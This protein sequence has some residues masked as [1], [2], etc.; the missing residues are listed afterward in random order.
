MSRSGESWR[1]SSCSHV[2]SPGGVKR[3]EQPGGFDEQY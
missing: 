3:P 1:H 2:V